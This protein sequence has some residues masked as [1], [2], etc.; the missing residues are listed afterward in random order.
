VAPVKAEPRITVNKIDAIKAGK[1]DGTIDKEF[2][3][4]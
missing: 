1:E 4:K 3:K 2:F